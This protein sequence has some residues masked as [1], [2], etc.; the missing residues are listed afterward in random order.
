MK[1]NYIQPS[2]TIAQVATMT[3]MQAASPAGNSMNVNSSIP[4][5][6]QW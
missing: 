2:V 3:L 6:D 4:T 1:R 5:D